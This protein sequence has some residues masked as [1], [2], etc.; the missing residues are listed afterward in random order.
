MLFDIDGT[1][2]SKSGPQHREALEHAVSRVFGVRASLDGISTHGML[3]TDLVTTMAQNA[4]V[5]PSETG[6]A[7]LTVT[8]RAESYYLRRNPGSLTGRVCPGARAILRRLERRGVPLLLVTGNFPRIGW[9]KLELA[10]LRE[11]FLAGAFAGMSSTRAG[12]ARL[13][14]QKA[15]SEG[16]AQA[17]SHVALVG[18]SPNDIEAAHANGIRSVAVCTGINSGEELQA[19]EPHVLVESLRQ[20]TLGVLLAR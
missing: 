20:L 9:K 8:R 7:M 5:P 11:F 13:A 10:G 1:L 3:D 18:D 6:D 4:G 17:E 2:I 12:L 16:W 15:R 19:Y 14:M